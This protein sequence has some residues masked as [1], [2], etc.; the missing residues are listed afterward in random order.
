MQAPSCPFPRMMRALALQCLSVWLCSCAT[1]ASL[2]VLSSNGTA[3]EH[4]L[5]FFKS[6]LSDPAGALSSWNTSN[7]LCRWR[8]VTCGRRH[9][10][11]VVALH[12]NSSHLAGR[13]VSPF[14]GNLTFLRTLNLGD[15]DFGGQVPPELGRLSRLQ[16]LNLSLNALQ[17]SVPAALGRCTKLRVLNL[18]NNLLRGEIPAQIGSL[19]NLEILN[20]FANDLS[21]HIPPSIANLSSLQTLNLGNNTLSGAIPPSI[22]RMP[23]LSLLSLQ[24]NNL[25]GLIPPPIWNISSLKGLSVVGNAL[26]GTIPAGAFAN[27]PLLQLF[28][29]SYNQF[30][31]HV[32]AILANSSEL[33]RIELGYNFFSG[34][35]PPEVGGLQNLESLALSNNLLQATTPSDWNFMSTLSNCSQLQY[36]D[37]A[38]N[39]LGGM[40]PSSISN[41][42]T[43][44]VYLSLSR[45]R[46]LGN[47]PER[48]GN[49]LQL[50]VLSLENNLLTGTLPYSLSI[51]TNLGDLSLG[52]N[53]LSGSVPLTIGNLTQLSNLYLG[54]NTFSGSIPSTVGNL[55]SLL[56]IDFSTNNLTGII[57]SSLF[58]IST[59][60]LG[61]DLS[62][63]CLEGSIPSEIGNLKNLVEFRAASNRLSHEIP[64]TLGDC[65][66][67]QNIYLQNNFLEGSIPP[68][69]SRLKGLEILDL[70]S[71]K[72]SGQMPKFLEDLNTLHYLNLSFNNFVGEVPFTGIFTNATTVSVQGNDKL[73]GGIQDLHLPPCSFQSS[74]KNKLLL[75]TI[76]IP[77]VAVLGVIFLVFFLLAW[78]KQRSNGNPST[79]TIQGYPSV[80]Y[81][82]LAK[83]T[84]GFSTA[85][86][87]G[88]GTFG[89]VYKGNLGGDR[90]DSANI[91]AIKVL[92][93]QTPG[94][95]KSFT[96]ECEA[97]RNTRHRNLV[98]IMTL[99]SSIDSKGDDFK[100]I[101]FE[102]MPNGSLEDWLHP[103][104][105]EEKHLDI[106]KRV[107][108]LLDVG[109]ALDYLHSYGAAPIAHCDLKPSNVLLDVDLVAHV[110]DFGLARIL[111]E[112]NSFPQS[113]TSSMGF[114]GTIGYAAPE[115]GAGNVISIQGDVYSY[116]ILILEIVT[117]KRPT[118]SMFI[119]GLNLH[120]YA[121]MAI[122]GGVM[123]IVDMRLFSHIEKGS[124]ATDDSSTF[125]RTYNPSDERRI[126][127]LTSLLRLGVSCSQEMP[128][129]RMLIK[130]TIK[131]LR[132]IKDFLA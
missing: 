45:N 29:M 59:L 33:Q 61:L 117:G 71:N 94:A 115:Y 52:R 108:I 73:C 6:E 60:S 50:Q 24:F 48:I 64:P 103:D 15:N 91:V 116:G 43:S 39:E 31:G 79:A 3:D 131:E 114:R 99:C 125:S 82:T 13:P 26:S 92:K 88:S 102:F 110:G 96:V 89:S 123:D 38:S 10:E 54:Y 122:H 76:L 66:I 98:K 20:L 93:L 18:R 121:E 75:K 44:L 2:A 8:G 53:N 40:L 17:G 128:V 57:P 120:K 36:L 35:V 68:L 85:N 69:L 23:R 118:D 22:G 4:N 101:V 80:S 67:L 130:D 119:Q 27:L 111:T 127:C 34:T 30:H 84:N 63:N 106:L 7:P 37:L 77:V 81:L 55:A 9:P 51:L 109:Y 83:A 112:G 124:P 132:S 14:L 12:L 126:D 104:Q 47:I 113:S 46:I 90:G 78:N 41:L 72:L 86:L 5:L 107:S 74:K 58:N 56:N 100:A 95:L 28:Y 16:A 25:S 42:S 62:Y 32:P 65:E 105:N 19:E 70:S 49:L 87:L 129:S 11:R 1:A 97:I 21:G